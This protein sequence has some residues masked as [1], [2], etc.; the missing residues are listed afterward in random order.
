MTDELNKKVDEGWKERIA[1]EKGQADE[2]ISDPV[3]K[4]A[5]NE[6]PPEANFSMFISGLALQV[7]MQLGEIPNPVTKK[8]EKELEQAKYLID[9]L[10]M[11]KEKTANNLTKEEARLF[12]DTLYDL[13]M[14]FVTAAKG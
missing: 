10:A 13:R 11:L 2:P 12:E 9:I 4:H 6:E 8:K 14:R 7:L 5:R 3:D 1:K